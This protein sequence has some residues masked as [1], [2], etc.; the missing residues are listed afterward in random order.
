[1]I[2]ENF[3]CFVLQ[4]MCELGASREVMATRY[5][6]FLKTVYKTIFLFRFSNRPSPINYFS[7]CENNFVILVL[8]K[9]FL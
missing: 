8:L 9:S 7:V 4:Y 3:Q 5:I 2:R 1:M 6:L